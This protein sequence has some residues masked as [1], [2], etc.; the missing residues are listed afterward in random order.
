ME[1]SRLERGGPLAEIAREQG[2]FTACMPVEAGHGAGEA[3]DIPTRCNAGLQRVPTS[4][5]LQARLA[6]HRPE[7][8]APVRCRALV[9]PMRRCTGDPQPGQL[10]LTE[11]SGEP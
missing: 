1:W 7:P 11:L 10:P 8:E 5:L 2:T 6:M 4:F 9:R 3:K